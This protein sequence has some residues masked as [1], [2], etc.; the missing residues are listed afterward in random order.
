MFFTKDACIQSIL[1]K[2]L[3]SY[4]SRELSKSSFFK[5]SHFPLLR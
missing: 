4:F 5:Y 1:K 2:S 3:I